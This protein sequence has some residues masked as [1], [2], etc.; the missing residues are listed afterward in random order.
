MPLFERR[1]AHNIT[2]V[3]LGLTFALLGRF[4][5]ADN[6]LAGGGG[7]LML[8]FL[9]LVPI[10]L[11]AIT[12]HFSPA[13]RTN[14]WSFIFR[15][16]G[17]VLLFLV[18][19]FIFNLEGAIC[20]IIIGPLFIVLSAVGGV[21]YRL[22]TRNRHP[23]DNRNTFVVAGFALL[24]FVAA[25]LESQFAAP[26][27]FRRVQNTILI[28]APAEAVW[29]NIIRVPAISAQD[30]GPS[31]VD[32]IGFPRPVE[33]TLSF[34]GVGGVRHATFERGVEFIE[35]VDVW[36]PR[37]RISFRIVPNTATIPPTTFDEHVT[38]GGRF[39]DVL[40]G[41]YELQPAGPGRT[42]LVLY[43][44]QRLSTRLNPYAGLWTDFVMSEIQERILR[45]VAKRSEA[46][47]AQATSASALVS[48]RP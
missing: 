19:A 39:F 44:Q 34:E 16:W 7:L 4:A 1:N 5:F 48:G 14:S 32:K 20:L 27:D 40:R 13:K 43:S 30:L 2:A 17:T 33:A 12:E 6:A 9:V 18:T 35:T 25:P 36:E 47:A 46:E 37:R 45:V 29:H 26:D 31:L 38:V 41:T 10:G 3:L 23:D 8:G 15:S 11:G 24:P 21:L 42:R 22:L 28:N